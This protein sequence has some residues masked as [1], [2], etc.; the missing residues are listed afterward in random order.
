VGSGTTGMSRPCTVTPPK[1]IV[2]VALLGTMALAIGACGDSSATG[3]QSTSTRAPVIASAAGPPGTALGDGFTV[4][5]GT[6]LIG[7]PIPIGVA[8]LYQGQPIVDEGWTATSIAAGGDPIEI[9]D[10]YMRQAED[11]GLVQQPRTGCARDLDVTI[12]SAFARSTDA[13]EPRSLAATVVRGGRDDV[14]SDHVVV[15]FSTTDLYWE[16]GQVGG[17]GDQDLT[18]PASTAWP[19]L[20]SVGEPLGTAGETTHAVVVQE[21]SRLAGPPRLD[22]DD[23]TGGIVAILEVTGDPRSVLQTYLD[24]L[25]QLGLEGRTPEV[26]EIGDAVVTTAYPAEAGGDHFTI[27]LVERSGRPTW[28]VIE[29]THD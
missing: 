5:E 16:H 8:V 17:P 15:R 25:A 13:A 10:A 21:G 3:P 2:V 19:P 27:T 28:L 6:T 22:L 7:D 9:I 18:I 26:L 20:A 23:A 4:V 12:C 14:L 24:H 1:G 11:A 29:G